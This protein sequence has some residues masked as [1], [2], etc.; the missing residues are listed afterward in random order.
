M[1][2]IG[3]QRCC[4][5]A[6]AMLMSSAVYG[7][8]IKF[9]NGKKGKPLKVYIMAGQS[10]MTGMAKISTFEHLKMSP[11][12]VKEYADL[13]NKDGSLAT[14]DDVFV[15][16][17]KG[18]EGGTLYAGYGGEPGVMFGPEFAFGIYMHKK[19]QEPFL[20]IKTAE[21]GKNLSYDFRP[22]S[23]DQ[24][25]PKPGNPELVDDATV[26]SPL[27][28]LP[29]RIDLP[30]DWTPEKPYLAEKKKS[31]AEKLKRSGGYYRDMI[32]SS[33]IRGNRTRTR[34]SNIARSFPP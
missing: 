28:L 27:V 1:K 3:I 8:E 6:M 16:Q 13:F 33:G 20:I 2:K 14:L 32:W 18:K 9:N 23:A 15:S 4:V 5:A 31:E 19:L 22:P 12:A 17:W 11:D 24:W 21:G 26:K 29:E 25:I 30:D 10:N 7:Q 34:P